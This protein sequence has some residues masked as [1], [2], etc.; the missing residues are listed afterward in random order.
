MMQSDVVAAH[1]KKDLVRVRTN[2]LCHLCTAAATTIG[3]AYTRP[4]K[5]QIATRH[6]QKVSLLSLA[7]HK[8]LKIFFG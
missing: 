7:P 6:A 1:K 4:T 3:I 5:N 8:K 2:F